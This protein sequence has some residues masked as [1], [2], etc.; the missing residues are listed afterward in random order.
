MWVKQ[1]STTGLPLGLT[2]GATEEDIYSYGGNSGQ[3]YI[4]KYAA[5]TGNIVWSKGYTDGASH[6]SC[7][8]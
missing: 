7:A 1:S 3:Y 8:L 6:E 2:F 5:S 4:V